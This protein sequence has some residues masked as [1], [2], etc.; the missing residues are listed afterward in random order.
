MPN[1]RRKRKVLSGL[2]VFLEIVGLE[3]MAEDV[4]AAVHIRRAGGREFQIVGA[5]TMTPRTPNEV[6]TNGMESRLVFDIT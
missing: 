5:V 1:Q 4:R 6:R 3:V 2:E